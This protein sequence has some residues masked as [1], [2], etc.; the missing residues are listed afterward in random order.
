MRWKPH[1]HSEGGP[2]KPTGRKAGRAPRS[3]P[4][5]YVPTWSGTVFTAFV[6]DVYSRRI[7]GWRTTATMPT[8]LPLDALEMAL[9][10]RNQAGH[11]TAGVVHHSDAGS[12]TTAIRYAR[13]VRLPAAH[14]GGA[15]V[16]PA[17]RHPRGTRDLGERERGRGDRH[18]DDA[19]AKINEL[20]K[21]SNGG[22]GCYLMMAHEW[23]RP[24]AINRHYELFAQHV[25][26]RF[27]GSADRLL[28][29]ERAAQARWEELNTKQADALA[30]WTEKHAQE[31]AERKS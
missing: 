3:D 18:P 12:Q 20:Y 23:A 26:P 8:E 19:I 22:F 4:Y 31:K 24:E 10:T 6:S 29:A 2:R 9:W 15:P 5:T 13:L 28:G 1:V 14:C 27:Q 16:P 7:V 11:D 17:G 30:A 25:M 21:Q